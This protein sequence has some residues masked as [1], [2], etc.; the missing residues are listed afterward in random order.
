MESRNRDPHKG[1]K[2]MDCRDCKFSA[3]SAAKFLSG[4]GLSSHGVK[5]LSDYAHSQ[6][7]EIVENQLN[8]ARS[9]N[10]PLDFAFNNVP[11]LRLSRYETILKYKKLTYDILENE[12]SYFTSTVENSIRALLAMDRFLQQ[13]Q[14]F[15]FMVSPNPEY[16][17]NNAVAQRALEFG[18][19]T[20]AS[21]S[22]WN[23]S[24]IYSGVMMW[25]WDYL[26]NTSVALR[27]WTGASSVGASLGDLARVKRHKEE[28]LSGQSAFV[29]S[30]PFDSRSSSESTRAK[31][32][33]NDKKISILLALSSTDEVLASKLVGIGQSS[34]YPGVVFADQFEWVEK[35][36]TWAKGRNDVQL[37]VRLHPRDLP[38]KRENVQAAQYSKW[39]EILEGNDDL[40][41]VNYPGQEIS[42]REVCEVVDFVVTG[43]SSVAV[44]A[45]LLSKMVITYDSSLPG[46]PAD[47]HVSGDSA[48]KY[49]KNLEDA[50]L[51]TPKSDLATR[52][53]SWL[54]HKTV[55]GS[56]LLTGRLFEGL[57]SRGSRAFRLLF[58][59]IDRYFFFLWRPLELRATFQRSS[60]S[61]KLRQLFTEG[62][63]DLYQ[64]TVIPKPEGAKKGRGRNKY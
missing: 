12:D 6:D 23:L 54:V 50:I 27:N 34:N 29:Y 43:W 55:R 47:I 11:I 36:I 33:M 15:D 5:F 1:F 13:H 17:V 10:Y 44:E 20:Y 9:L 7:S 37:V 42:F 49:F 52:A 56:I 48:A 2:T 28:L 18:V 14:N 8:K 32:G 59:G 25:R 30:T 38:N 40:V 46:Y 60:D 58:G 63:P 45:L 53:E 4:K 41:I 35:T 21:V 64:T 22:S 51:G 24:E 19:P 16:G 31:L 57:R 61:E 39:V 3:K 62:Q 26:P